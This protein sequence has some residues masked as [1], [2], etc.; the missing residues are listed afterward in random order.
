MNIMQKVMPARVF[1]VGIA[2]GHAVTFSGGLAKAGKTAVCNIY[3]SFLQR[4]YDNII[5]DIALQ[6]LHVVLT[7]DRAGIVGQDGATHH[8]LLD[9]AFLRPIPNL[10]IAAPMSAQDLENMLYTAVE[11]VNGPIAI[12]YPRGAAALEPGTAEWQ[13]DS[14]RWQVLEPGKGRKLKDGKQ[15]AVLSIGAIGNACREAIADLDIAHYDM[16]WLKPLDTAILDEAAQ[17]PVVY[18]AEDGILKGG[19]GSAVAEYFAAKGYTSKIVMIGVNDQFVEHGT[20]DELYHMLGMDA[21]GIRATIM[22]G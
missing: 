3:S 7:I 18:T 20:P 1:D 8:G 5:H 9:L 15:A 22:K 17:Y 2:E 13:V 4:S 6:K 10:M 11:K 16:R 21:E 19:L 14:S 12:R